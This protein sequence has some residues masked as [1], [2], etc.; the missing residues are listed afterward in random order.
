M[1]VR[2]GLWRKLST[3]ELMLLNCGVGEDSWEFLGLQGDPTSLS[4]RRS[5]LGIHWK[6]WCWKW[7]SN[8]LPPHAKSWLTGK[9]SDA[10]RDWEQEEKG[11]TE[12]EIARWHH[13]L[14]GLEFRWTPGAGDGQGSL[15]CCSSW[16][17]KESDTTEWPNWLTLGRFPGEGKGYPLHYS[18]IENSMDC[19]VQGT[20]KS[21]TQ[22]SDVSSYSQMSPEW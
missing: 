3:K 4:S 21:Q 5:V 12:D 18:D 14:D 8:T 10:G 15:A 22:L 13:R 6:D 2:V 16:G 20:T 19:I 1:D 9:D 11:M 7:N 17:H